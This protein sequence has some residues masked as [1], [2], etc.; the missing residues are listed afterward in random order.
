MTK[1]ANTAG[2]KLLNNFKMR[3][4][5]NISL[6]SEATGK[7]CPG[8]YFF[9]IQKYICLLAF[10]ALCT[11]GCKPDIDDPSDPEVIPSFYDLRDHQLVTP[12]K[13][14]NGTKPS[15]ESDLGTAVGLCWAFS[16]LSSL[17]SN[18]LKQGIVSNPNSDEA[19]LSPWYLGN[20]IGY[21]TPCYEFNS[22]LIPDAEPPTTFG[23]YQEN[24]GW[25]GG[26]AFWLADYLIGG[27]K[28]PLWK[29]APMPIEDMNTHNTLTMPVTSNL[30]SYFI[31]HMY[32]YFIDDF[33]STTE[34]KTAIKEYILSHG[35]IQSMIHLEFIDT[36]G[37][38][39]Q[40]CQGTEYIGSRFL[41]KQNHNMF[42]YEEDNL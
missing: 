41:D 13:N 30:R 12:V 27:K 11:G 37:S 7:L 16:A 20:Y 2:N 18:L 6:L 28:L 39:R 42:T 4:P 19:N 38:L 29:D 23:Y 5:L 25:G 34:Y 14:Q 33:S 26:G 17:E 32:F 9:N 35:A 15:G 40:I 1:E 3:V 21:N 31:R 36:E 24:C 10:I 8:G 22:A